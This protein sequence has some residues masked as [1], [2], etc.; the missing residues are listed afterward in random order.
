MNLTQRKLDT[1][2]KIMMGGLIIKAG[3]D[4]LHKTNKAA[5]LG[6]LLEAKAKFESTDKK[7]RKEAMQHY[8]AI[9]AKAFGKSFGN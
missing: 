5:L 9:G 6:I 8:T 3:L 7:T 2:N 4:D 1:R